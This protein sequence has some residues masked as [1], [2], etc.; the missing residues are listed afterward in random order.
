MALI[1]TFIMLV[2]YFVFFRS[3]KHGP[4]ILLRILFFLY[5]ALGIAGSA[6]E[7]SELSPPVYN[8]HYPS[9]AFLALC[10]LI[11]SSG[12]YGFRA[13]SMSRV[14]AQVRGQAMI[15]NFLVVTQL[16][17]IAFFLPIAAGNLVGDIARNRMDATFVA[18]QL[19]QTGILNTMATAACL[20]FVASLIFAFIRLAQPATR[21]TWWRVALLFV[22]SLS[23]VVYVLA[24]IGRD[25]II[26]WTM[27]ALAAFLVFRPHLNDRVRSLIVAIIGVTILVMMV[28]FFI[29]TQARFGGNLL[30][31]LL[32]YFG[33]QIQNF[34]DYSTIYRPR[35]DGL[36]NFPLFYG[37][38][39]D[40]T[41]SRCE[42]W[43]SAR[44][45]IFNIYLGQGKEPWLFATFISDWVADFGYLGTFVAACAFSALCWML[46]PA[47]SGKTKITLPRLLLIMFL[48][49]IP[50]WGVFYF[51]F[52]ISNGYIVVNLI[53]ITAVWLVQ[54]FLPPPR[55]G[56]K[57]GE[58][59]RPDQPIIHTRDLSPGAQ[60][61][62][63]S[64]VALPPDRT[65]G[66][67]ASDPN[68]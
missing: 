44:P 5:L 19:A 56:Q 8:P 38:L 15:E 3:A 49:L 52:G 60:S 27:T 45:S 23:Y 67:S 12:F 33:S 26:Y 2:Y 22:S 53:F 62:A 61:R 28:P 24:Y 20:L 34:G 55:A 43:T 41:S 9:A 10:V 13:A 25:G 32:E 63:M 30:I 58:Y 21:D 11:A 64:M 6:L 59:S 37:W 16:A 54:I 46:C 51:R 50:Y 1:F 48:F 47:S 4:G 57:F 14:I 65:G 66:V 42:V 39:C 68:Q 17:A 40:L 35:T 18:D 31:S 7:L 29:I 36:Q